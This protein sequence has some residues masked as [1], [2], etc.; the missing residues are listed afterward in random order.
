MLLIVALVLVTLHFNFKVKHG[1]DS[2]SVPHAGVVLYYKGGYCLYRYL[3]IYWRGGIIHNDAGKDGG[4]KTWI[5]VWRQYCWEY[6]NTPVT[7][8]AVLLSQT[9]NKVVIQLQVTWHRL[10]DWMNQVVCVIYVVANSHAIE[11]KLHKQQCKF[12]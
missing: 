10:I 11:N 6:I 3:W 5:V 8:K 4:L 2:S 12:S 7:I 9:A 1:I